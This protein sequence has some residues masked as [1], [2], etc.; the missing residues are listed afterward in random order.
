MMKKWRKISQFRKYYCHTIFFLGLFWIA[1]LELFLFLFFAFYFF[2]FIFFCSIT[3]VIEKCRSNQNRVFL[4][5]SFPP[6]PLSLICR[7]IGSRDLLSGYITK[8]GVLSSRSCFLGSVD[9][10]S[11]FFLFLNFFTP[12]PD[13]N[14]CLIFL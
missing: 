2:R 8:L 1:I 9:V 13:K 5:V 4:L 11:N 12:D 6:T 3:L 7:F 10:G 14:I